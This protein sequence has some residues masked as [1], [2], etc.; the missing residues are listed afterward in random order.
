MVK[1]ANIKGYTVIS[2]ILSTT[3]NST[4]YCVQRKIKTILF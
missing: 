4:F 3:A 1:N 2:G